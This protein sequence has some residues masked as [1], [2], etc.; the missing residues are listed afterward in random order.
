MVLEQLDDLKKK[1][2]YLAVVTSIIFIAISGLFFGFM[3]FIMD[4]TQTGLQSTDCVIE[5]NTLVSSCQELF[6]LSIYPF[7]VLK[8]L[9]VWISFFF[10]FG[11]VIACLTVGYKSG[12]SSVMLGVMVV[13]TI[14]A[15]YAGIEISNIYRTLLENAI[16]N[17]M[18]VPF[19]IYNRVMLNFPWFTFILGLFSVMLGIINFQRTPIND[20]S[21]RAELN[22]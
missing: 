10:I 6:N 19:T 9:L 17:S 8:T 20:P 3:Y 21:S 13:F 18:M 2:V 7:L 11:L 14:I 22:F 15:T 5:N 4:V 1:G 16:V 12:E